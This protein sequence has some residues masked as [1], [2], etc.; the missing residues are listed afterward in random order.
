MGINSTGNKYQLNR[1]EVK[2]EILFDIFF[3]IVGD[4]DILMVLEVVDLFWFG[5]ELI[6]ISVFIFLIGLHMDLLWD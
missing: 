1:S 6:L 5:E 4:F 3:V 2:W